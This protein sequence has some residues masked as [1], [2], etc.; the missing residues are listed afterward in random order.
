MPSPNAIA[1][2]KNDCP[3]PSQNEIAISF[4][5]A[6]NN[7]RVPLNLFE[8]RPKIKKETFLLL[9]NRAFPTNKNLTLSITMTTTSNT[10]IQQ[11]KEFIGDRFNQLDGKIEKLADK[12]DN[13]TEKVNSIDKRL[14][15]V[16]SKVDS[17]EKRL[18]TVE[19][20][21]PDISSI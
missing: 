9:N 15:V 20:K 11:L 7:S 2:L 5:T 21:L 1:P 18:N 8:P 19:G 17:T 14:A 6:R 12:V 10:E 16:E 13:L 3:T 4:Q